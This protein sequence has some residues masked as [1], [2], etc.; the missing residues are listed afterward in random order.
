MPP[1][2]LQKQ[3]LRLIE[4]NFYLLDDDNDK[5]ITKRQARLLF[6]ALGQTSTNKELERILD[7]GIRLLQ[8]SARLAP[9]TRRPPEA[10]PLGQPP[11]EEAEPRIDFDG[12]V[13]IF[14]SSYQT[15]IS[16][17]VVVEGLQ[18]FDPELT[19]R[20]SLTQ[21][22][23]LLASPMGEPLTGSDLEDILRLASC[24][25]REGWSPNE[26]DYVAFI[27]KLRSG[28]GVQTL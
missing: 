25:T 24:F 19:G 10:G 7:E 20:M 27:E 28:C 22:R 26:I 2:K 1:I 9:V 12:F 4:Q 15:P 5:H 8:Q 13:R 23:S 18:L 21:L 17:D 3:H 11:E 6:R 14:E 16:A